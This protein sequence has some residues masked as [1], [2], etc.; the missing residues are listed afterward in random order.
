MRTLY[1]AT[2]ALALVPELASAQ[3]TPG[4]CPED[5]C[6]APDQSGGGCGCGCG[7]S[8]LINMTDLGDTYQYSDDYDD[9]G[10]EDDFDNCPFSPNVDQ[11]DADGDGVGN[12]C[13]ACPSRSDP[14]QADADADGSGDLCDAD[15]DNDG[16]DNAADNCG[17]LPNPTQANSDTDA[18]GDACDTDDDGDGVVDADD[19]CPLVANPAQ[20]NG[21][22][23]LYGDA[24]DTDLDGDLVMDSVDN[25][26]Q[27][28]N[29]EQ[30][31]LDGDGLGDPCDS[32]QDGDGFTNLTDNCPA[33]A[34]PEREDADHDG[35]GDACD[36]YYCYVVDLESE[37]LDPG[38]PFTAYAMDRYEART[39]EPFM[40][41][42]FANRRSVGIRYEWTIVEAPAG[43]DAGIERPR[44]AV[45]FST[46]FEYHYL[47]DRAVHF[48]PDVP[49]E[50]VVEVHAELVFADEQYPD[51]R[52]STARTLVVVE[53]PATDGSGSLCAYGRGRLGSVAPLGLLLIAIGVWQRS[54]RKRR[55]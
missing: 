46:P 40:L 50:Y 41:R 47:V 14:D 33:L 48:E 2:L 11:L 4:E 8:I 45:S 30:T 6:G 22:P 43:S 37:C 25:C 52:T 34:N 55:G 39:G 35:R 49:G 21:D 24:C 31:D 53:G 28:V 19:N 29:A 54:V 36:D 10:M 7:C 26:Q 38:E 16:V 1:A 17:L 18:L 27:V 9:D 44:G 23:D 51:R 5:L 3:D 32:D 15:A 20:A 12:A 42:L 13:D